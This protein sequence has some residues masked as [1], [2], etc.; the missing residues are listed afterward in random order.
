MNM[1][2][3]PFGTAE[4]GYAAP[5]ATATK[6]SAPAEPKAV[7]EAPRQAPKST[8]G[9]PPPT[10]A[11]EEEYSPPPPPEVSPAPAATPARPNRV[12]VRAGETITTIAKRWNVSPESLMMHNDLVSPDIKPGQVLK[13]PPARK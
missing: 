5:T 6:T 9:V 1:N 7:E 3:G 2:Q 12:T 4:P 13:L 8:K 11:A 10:K